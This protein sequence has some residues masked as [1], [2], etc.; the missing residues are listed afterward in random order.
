[1]KKLSAPFL[2]FLQ[3]TGLVIYII[4]ISSFFTFVTP[5][6]DKANA[7]FYAPLI[8]LLL[9]VISAVISATLVLGR[10]G[11]LF[12]EKK[13]KESFTV[14]GWAVGWGIFYFTVFVLFLFYI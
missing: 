6:L 13:Y 14:I 12:W 11:V 9:F 4:L 8:M 3:T 1:M 2:S 10:A 5:H 7:E